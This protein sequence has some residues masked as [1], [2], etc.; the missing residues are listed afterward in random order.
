[1]L[2][3]DGTS[4]D[5]Y[6][7][8]EAVVSKFLALACRRPRLTAVELIAAL[9]TPL[10]EVS[11]VRAALHLSGLGLS[12]RAAIRFFVYDFDGKRVHLDREAFVRH[13]LGEGDQAWL[14]ARLEESL[15][16]IQPLWV[17]EPNELIN[18]EDV[19]DALLHFAAGCAATPQL[20]N[21]DVL[22]RMLRAS[23]EIAELDGA[24][25]FQRLRERVCDA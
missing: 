18:S 20:R 9:R 25:T 23:F 19:I 16:V 12:R 2:M 11:L 24:D 6:L 8:S 21:R 3:T 7:W 10:I 4:I 15:A 17:G 14:R 13:L 5:M 1:L 22:E